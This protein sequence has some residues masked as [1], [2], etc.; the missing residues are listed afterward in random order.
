MMIIALL[1]ILRISAVNALKDTMYQMT[2]SASLSA[3]MRTVIL[4]ILRIGA[5][6]A[7]K[8]TV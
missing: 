2:S 5:V 1:A 4:A 7:R 3:M 6:N 8:D